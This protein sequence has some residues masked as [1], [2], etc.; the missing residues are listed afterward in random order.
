MFDIGQ[1][2]VCVDDSNWVWYAESCCP[3]RPVKGHTYTVRGFYRVADCIGV[4][5]EEILNPP[6]EFSQ[7]YGMCEP[8]FSLHRFRPIKKTDSSVFEAM[9]VPTP[10]VPELV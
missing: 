7:P 2:V 8:N 1:Q 9:L 6:F 10:Q 5:L 3:N 4:H